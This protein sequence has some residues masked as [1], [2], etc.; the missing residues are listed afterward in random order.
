MPSFAEVTANKNFLS[1][2]GYKFVITR[3]PNVD[4][5]CQSVEFPS[6]TLNSTSVPNPFQ[7]LPVAGTELTY[8]NI[9]INFKIDEDLSNYKEIYNWMLA[10]GFPESYEQYRSLADKSAVD[11]QRIRSD[12]SL[13]ILSSSKNPKHEIKFFDIF[14][15]GLSGMKFDSTLS[16]VAYLEANAEFIYR[17]FTLDPTTTNNFSSSQY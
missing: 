2:L 1:P 4:Y 16:D 11:S 9:T 13:V 7:K 10:L 5:F 8:G 3:L 15:V 12:A 17:M 6:V 14:P